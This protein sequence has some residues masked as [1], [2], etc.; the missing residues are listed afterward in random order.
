[1]KCTIAYLCLVTFCAADSS[2]AA[3]AA[4]PIR[5]VV[6]MLQM[7]QKKVAAEAEREKQLYDKFMCYCKSSG[8]AL[9]KSVADA[10]AKVPQLQSDIEEADAKLAQLKEDVE[11]HQADRA[12]AKEAMKTATEVRKKE[13]AAFEAQKTELSSYID[14]MARAIAALEKG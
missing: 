14:A 12:A 11:S 4:N 10:D 3:V 8:G 6:T 1:M 13:A 5:K 9:E 2:D 7:M